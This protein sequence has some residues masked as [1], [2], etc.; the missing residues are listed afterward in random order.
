M[1]TLDSI[2]FVFFVA[3][4]V[5]GALL[6]VTRRNLLHAAMCLITMLFGTAGIF[7]QLQAEF[8]FI[9]QI[10]LVAGG[11]MTLF[12]FTIR[13]LGLKPR[14]SSPKITRRSLF[15][16]A[17]ALIL[18]AQVWTATMAGR[19]S[20]RLPE[21]QANIAPQNTDAVGNALFRSFVVPFG[22]TSVLLLVAM[23]G[24]TLMWNRRA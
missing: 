20:L 21:M 14:Q 24:A 6:M 2:L 8:L 1:N 22:I 15:T 19:T 11:V 4:A 23:I 5:G 13:S 9:V 17:L 3:L 12:V 10:F 16:V 18:V 7:L